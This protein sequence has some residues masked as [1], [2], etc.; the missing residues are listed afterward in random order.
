MYAPLKPLMLWV[1]VDGRLLFGAYVFGVVVFGAVDCD[2]DNI[3]GCF[4]CRC[5]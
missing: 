1:E 5:H 4:E 3:S 2:V